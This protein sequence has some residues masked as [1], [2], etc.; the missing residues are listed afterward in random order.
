MKKRQYDK[1]SINKAILFVE[2]KEGSIRQAAK[3]FGVPRTSIIYKLANPNTKFKSGPDSILTDEEEKALVNYIISFGKRGFPRKKED[4]LDS[5]QFFLEEN[6]RSTPF[7]NGRPGDK[8]FSLFMKRHPNLTVRT[9]EGVTR[10]SACVSETDIRMWF[11]EIK[12]Y[13]DEEDLNE[14]VKD[15][16]RIYN[17]DETCFHICPKTGKVI[18]EKGSKMFTSLKGHHQKRTLL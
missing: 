13:F 12:K 3:L 5:V 6:P 2:N 9:A 8:W 1:E 11:S 14:V 15:P 18:S 4:I 17:A 16:T 7:K 10:V